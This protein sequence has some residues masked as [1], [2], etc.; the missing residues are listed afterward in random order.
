LPESPK[1]P[2]F[3]GGWPIIVGGRPDRIRRKGEKNVTLPQKKV[4]DL[5]R[6]GDTLLAEG[7]LGVTKIRDGRRKGSG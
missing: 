2:Q 6:S 1:V 5:S 7:D 4:G 3:Q